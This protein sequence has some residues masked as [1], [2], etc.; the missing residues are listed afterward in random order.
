[1]AAQE[2]TAAAVARDVDRPRE[3]QQGLSMV[4]QATLH[5]VLLTMALLM[6]FPFF[7][8]L[9]TALR[10]P[11]QEADLSLIPQPYLA[12]ENFSRA[13]NY[14]RA[15]RHQQLRHRHRLDVAGCR[16]ERSGRLRLRQVQVPWPRDPLLHGAGDADG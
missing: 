7:W 6:F 16:A 4:Q 9:A 5:V 2:S 8:M 14:P 1:M 3:R 13:W 10:P 15:V 11:G 12:W